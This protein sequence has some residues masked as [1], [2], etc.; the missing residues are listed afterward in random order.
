MSNRN[1]V[2]GKTSV[3]FF[4]LQIL[5]TKR[6]LVMLA[7]TPDHWPSHIQCPKHI[8]IQ[9]IFYQMVFQENNKYKPPISFFQPQF[10]KVFY[11]RCFFWFSRFSPW[12]HRRF[13]IAFQGA[14]LRS[15]LPLLG[16]EVG[17][18]KVTKVLGIQ[19]RQS[20]DVCWF[21]RFEVGGTQ[22]KTRKGGVISPKGVVTTT[23]L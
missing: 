9:E 20:V 19:A 15:A 12:H 10:S 14:K 23:P 3:A 4:F 13:I 6:E 16:H 5:P 22:Q 11:C 17:F 2:E 18:S 21:R 1:D 8:S 7:K